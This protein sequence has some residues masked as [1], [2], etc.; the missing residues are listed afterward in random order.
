MD[1]ITQ[2][3]WR[4]W[5]KK[6][7][8]LRFI[9]IAIWLFKGKSKYTTK[10]LMYQ[11]IVPRKPSLLRFPSSPNVSLDFVSGN[12]RTLGKFCLNKLIISA[13]FYFLLLDS[14]WLWLTIRQ[15]QKQMSLKWL[16]NIKAATTLI[17]VSC[18]FLTAVNQADQMKKDEKKSTFFYFDKSGEKLKKLEKF[19]VLTFSW[20][21]K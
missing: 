19:L 7:C 1:L 12:I 4:L 13:V 2:Q 11:C 6:F 17:W 10:H 9:V 14:L 16:N 21:M 15:I 8:R 20:E 5:I 3:D 18:L